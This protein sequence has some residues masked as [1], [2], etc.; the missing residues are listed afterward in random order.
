MTKPECTSCLLWLIP[1]VLLLVYIVVRKCLSFQKVKNISK[2]FVLITGCDKGFGR[3]A[4]IELDLL[5]FQIIATCL[6]TQGKDDLERVCSQRTK[7]FLLDVTKTKQIKEVY[8]EVNR[9]IPKDVGLWALINNAGIFIPGPVEWQPLDAFK[10][11]ADV[12]LWGVIDMTKT[13]LP[14]VRK[15][16]GRIVN[17]SSIAGRMPFT[18]M[19]AYCITKFGVETFSDV[20]RREVKPFGVKV[21]LIEPSGYKTPLMN[22]EYMKISWNKEWE[23]L[24]DEAKDVYDDEYRGKAFKALRNTFSTASDDIGMVVKALEVAVTSKAPRDR[25]LVGLTASVLAFIAFLPSAIVDTLANFAVP[26]SFGRKNS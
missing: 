24:S 25:Y 19:S 6:T 7:V 8:S 5:G 9:F 23:D 4:A 22:E 26:T 16:Q 17:L 14:L 3:L 11:T 2:K 20:L 15:A 1:A 10:R 12:N 13:F 18:Y 21:I